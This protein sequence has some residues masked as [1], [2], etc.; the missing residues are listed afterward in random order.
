MSVMGG[1]SQTVIDCC[2]IVTSEKDVELYWFL[3]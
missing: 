3:F 2:Y 1:D